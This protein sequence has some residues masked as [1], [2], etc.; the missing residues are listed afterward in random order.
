MKKLVI[1]A[2]STLILIGCSEKIDHAITKDNIELD[3]DELL[4]QASTSRDKISFLLTFYSMVGGPDS[5]AAFFQTKN[6]AREVSHEVSGADYFFNIKKLQ[7]YYIENDVTFRNVFAEYD[8]IEKVE[9]QYNP[10]FNSLF[11]L[12]DSV[13]QSKQDSIDNEMEIAKANADELENSISTK[14][15]SV[16]K[17]ESNYRDKLSIG[18]EVSKN[19]QKTID[20]V[21]FQILGFDKLNN[22]IFEQGL[23]INETLEPKSVYYWTFTE[24]EANYDKF[25]Y[26]N[27]E[28]LRYETKVLKI[29]IDG[30]VLMPEVARIMIDFHSTLFGSYN[31]P[32]LL[33]GEC[34]HLDSN[35]QYLVQL[36]DLKLQMS[37]ERI[38][39]APNVSNFEKTLSDLFY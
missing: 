27:S 6:P 23:K 33:E 25:K 28:N 20:A 3:I 38:R 10:L 39:I 35:H 12:I 7:N 17:Y 29:Y 4:N 5:L 8:S 32:D 11:F 37:E 24:Y 34:V 18:V 2:L 1:L 9:I 31:R 16:K 26:I 14:I 13:C 19:T 21:S 30:T 15:V 36:E 22:Q